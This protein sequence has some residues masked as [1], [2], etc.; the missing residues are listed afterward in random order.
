MAPYLRLRQ[1]CLV[2][3]DLDKIVDQ[4][5]EVFAIEVCHRDPKVA[6]YGLTNALMPVGTS[7]LEVVSPLAPGQHT[8]A[9]RYLERR[10]GD[11]G[12][13]VINDCDDVRRYRQRAAE[14]GIRIV[15]DRSYEAKADLLQLHPRD[16]GGA[17][18][19]FDHHVG[20]ELLD[21]AY[22]WAGPEW[23][24]HVRTSR[25]IG[26]DGVE[27][28]SDDPLQLATR[29]AALVQRDLEDSG[30]RP[31]INLDRGILRFARTTDGSGEGI[32]SIDM[33]VIDPTAILR[34]ASH[35][36]LPILSNGKAIEICGVRFNLH[37]RGL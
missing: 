32:C 24:Q 16:T 34:A 18:L 31:S 28:Q 25:V 1:I 2:A 5:C 20:G 15:E 14:L 7:F 9:G 10:G 33:S 12:Y 11:G 22:H 26:F 21:G 35:C 19:E 30:E 29:W 17:I 3:N 23:Q 27:L 6:R 4:L 36:G 13:M 37:R 8:A